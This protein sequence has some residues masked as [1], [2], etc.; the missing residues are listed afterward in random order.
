MPDK[1]SV[2]K[3]YKESILAKLSASEIYSDIKNQREST[4]GWV[5]GLCPF[6]KDTRN[7]FAYHRDTLAWVC[8]SPTC[9]KG[10]VFDFLML[11]SGRN[12]KDTLT[13]LGEKLGIPR[14]YAEMP[15]RPP[16]REEMVK[17]WQANLNEEIRRYLREKRGLSDAT[18]EK[19]Q[20]GW[21]VKRQRNT[22]P[23]RDERGNLVNIRLY[24]AKKDPKI[25]NYVD[26][27]F[28]YGT[29]A[30]LYG[31][32]ELVKH[33]GKQVI[34]PEGEFDRLLL[35]Q[36]NF[37]AVTSTHGCSVFRAEWVPYFKGK[38]VVIIYDCDSEGQA[39]ANNIVL[40]AFKNVEINS[41]KNVVL[42]L[43]G[44]KD[45]KDITDYFHNPI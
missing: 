17:I 9:G 32:D 31:L 28:K 40:K 15:R 2:W 41:V 5:T 33:K 36:E 37:M 11:T 4:D 23:I 6:H 24:N 12:F 7:S 38:D 14:P 39:A 34:I 16:I 20:I 22:I 10:S 42:P 21:D 30:R 27:K 43:K 13:G 35:Q 26:G 25:I 19:Y 44:E 18:I 8:F 1:D 29:P 3:K 45:D